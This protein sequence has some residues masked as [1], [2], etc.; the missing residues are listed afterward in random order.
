MHSNHSFIQVLPHAHPNFF[1]QFFLSQIQE[2]TQYSHFIK[3]HQW[4]LKFHF[5]YGQSLVIYSLLKLLIQKSLWTRILMV[6]I[7]LHLFNILCSVC[8]ETDLSKHP[9]S[10]TSLFEKY[11]QLHFILTAFECCWIDRTRDKQNKTCKYMHLKHYL[12]LG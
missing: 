4:F 5:D 12:W 8:P 3:K 9:G 1:T 6:S 2:K 10:T 11:L 7:S